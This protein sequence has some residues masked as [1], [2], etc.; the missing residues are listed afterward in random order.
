[1][2]K[3]LGFDRVRR[4]L[5]VRSNFMREV[6]RSES[7]VGHNTWVRDELVKMRDTAL[8]RCETVASIG[9]AQPIAAIAKRINRGFLVVLGAV[10][11]GCV[12]AWRHP[13]ADTLMDILVSEAE[14]RE[15]LLPDQI[16]GLRGRDISSRLGIPDKFVKL[17]LDGKFLPSEIVVNPLN[18]YRT[19]V[20]AEADFEA[21]DD[22]YIKAAEIARRVG[23]RAH[24]IERDLETAG[25]LPAISRQESGTA[26]YERKQEATI[27][28]HL[29]EPE[30]N[31]RK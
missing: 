7:A 17:L 26:F 13:D 11:E 5:F 16:P 25:I 21:F 8:D 23:K 1:M 2:A 19:T 12:Q 15:K 3:I 9:D 28:T 30:L 14:C 27:K 29:C 4:D 18:A 20:I 24:L 6:M 10:I 22:R 31:L